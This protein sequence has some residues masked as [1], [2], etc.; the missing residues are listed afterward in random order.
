MNTQK[1]IL[2]IL[3][4]WG[5]APSWGG[6]A[7]EL[8]ET[9]NFDNYWRK[10]PHT[11]LKAAE[12]AVGLP[13]H[14][15][16]NSEVGHLNI[17]SGQ[18]VRQNLPGINAEIASGTFFSNPV[19]LEAIAA[20]EKNSSNLHLIG[21]LSDG[22]IHSHINHLFSLLSY[23]KEKK[24]NRVYIHM[25][26]DGRDTEPMQALHYLEILQEKIKELG[27]G[28]I[29][30][31]IGRF[32]AMDREKHWEK[33]SQVYNLLTLGSAPKAESA[34]KAISLS[35][36][37][38]KFD[39]FIT[40]TIIENHQPFVPISDNDS[41]IFFNFRADRTKELTTAFL[42]DKFY[43]FHRKKFLKNL[44]YAT[45]AYYEEYEDK[46][47]VKVIFRRSFNNS[48]LAK[49]ISEKNL[50]QYHLAETTKYAH[51]TLFFNGEQD[52]KYPGETNQMV[53]SPKVATYDLKPEMSARRIADELTENMHK[54]D[55]TVVNFANPDMVG[56]TGN[57]KAAV[58]ACEEVD[59]CLGEVVREAQKQGKVV[60]VSA[61][62]GNAEQMINPNTGEPHTEHTIN[63]V[64][65]ILI[66][67]NP[68][69]QSPLREKGV[70]FGLTLSDIAPTILKILN[71]EQPKE[72]T[73]R[74]LV[75]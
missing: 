67:D 70:Q 42:K 1:V 4:G 43:H 47:P 48:T 6:N 64:P 29:S 7:V 13:H 15:P 2:V 55:F 8:A 17:G 14:E 16:G 68:E 75:E 35:Y 72:M 21:L 71:I 30:S 39:E 62:H 44:Y 33:I 9:P 27:V 18:I 60:I 63:P 24:F 52:I 41:V 51:V 34:E 65:F 5:Y 26:T 11:T 22:G 19:L 69:L 74:S 40:P 46:L 59:F 20:A 54:Y 3:D 56:H 66:S 57:L 23:C 58:K 49:I 73:G 38:N 31:V 53:P 37:Q 61:D 45:F 12:E 50:K 10:Y 36:R 25:I 28:H 32:Y